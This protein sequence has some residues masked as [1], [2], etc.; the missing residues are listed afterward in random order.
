VKKQFHGRT[1]FDAVV[2][3]AAHSEQ[4]H[5]HENSRSLFRPRIGKRAG[6]V[7]CQTLNA[8]TAPDILEQNAQSGRLAT[9]ATI[10]T[11]RMERPFERGAYCA[12]SRLNNELGDGNARL[13][14]L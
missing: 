8:R 4:V 11:G 10:G 13:Q 6:S 14:A 12:R 1:D 5:G 2:A 3:V 9:K 7:Y